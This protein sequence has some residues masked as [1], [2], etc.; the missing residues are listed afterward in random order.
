MS[1][2]PLYPFS[3]NRISSLLLRRGRS[4]TMTDATRSFLRRGT[5]VGATVMAL[6]ARSQAFCVDMGKSLSEAVEEAVD[7]GDYNTSH[8]QIIC[9]ILTHDSLGWAFT[10]KHGVDEAM[11]GQ[12]GGD[13]FKRILDQYTCLLQQVSVCMYVCTIYGFI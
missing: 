3:A 4:A 8:S 7:K 11:G 12:S 1:F 13:P 9:I 5:V 6:S 2:V 10:V